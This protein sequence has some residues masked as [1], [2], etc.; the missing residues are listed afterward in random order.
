MV[1]YASTF[2][3]GDH[4]VISGAGNIL[5]SHVEKNLDGVCSVLVDGDSRS[6]SQ[7]CLPPAQPS[8]GSSLMNVLSQAASDIDKDAASK[9][10]SESDAGRRQ[11]CVL[12][13]VAKE[14]DGDSADTA[15]RYIVKY[16]KP[17]TKSYASS[18][19]LNNTEIDT[20]QFQLSSQ[21]PGYYYSNIH[22]IDFGMFDPTTQPLISTLINTESKSSSTAD[23]DKGIFPLKEIDFPSELCGD[24][25]KLTWNGPLKKFG[26]VVNTDVSTGRGIHW[27]SIFMDFE[28]TPATIEYFNS[29]GMDVKNA[30]F[31]KWLMSL[32]LDISKDC[33]I[34]CRYVR[35][36]HIQHQRSNTS[37][38]GSYSLYYIW[39]RL[40]GTPVE[41][42]ADN[43]IDDESMQMFRK[44]IL[45]TH[46]PEV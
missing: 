14:G 21:F 5:S 32:A 37:N 40:N 22:M 2:L 30:E 3:M 17:A 25:K 12:K 4:M 26:C 24:K 31:K 9:C 45:S 6:A 44:Y 34:D 13:L 16:F 35:T 38:C 19:W 1:N 46:T 8:H 18:Y 7:G 41:W 23:G 39:K 43:K 42:F 29:S 11:L 10:A 33:G 36:T 28:S 27:F 15:K 20:L